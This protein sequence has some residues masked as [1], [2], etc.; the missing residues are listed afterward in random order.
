[1]GFHDVAKRMRSG[2][3]VDE[4]PM[5]ENPDDIMARAL[6]A[7]RRSSRRNDLVLGV[8]AVVGGGVVAV[9]WFSMMGQWT[10]ALLGGADPDP[11][12]SS[13]GLPGP[14]VYAIGGLALG[15][16]VVGL[17]K[18]LRGLGVLKR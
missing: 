15:A 4:A 5:A 9:L 2:R 16:I 12:N 18:I 17:R 6:E 7:E 11:R 1:M 13:M 14:V 8:L 10:R 3:E